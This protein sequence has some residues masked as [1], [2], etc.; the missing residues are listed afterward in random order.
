[1]TARDLFGKFELGVS[2]RASRSNS[3]RESDAPFRILVIGDFSGRKNRGLCE[4]IASRRCIKIDP[5]NFDAVLA[6]LEPQLDLELGGIRV[7]LTFAALDDFHPDRI[8]A[9]VPMVRDATPASFPSAPAAA[10]ATP[11]RSRKETDQ[12]TLQRLL[13]GASPATGTPAPSQPDHIRNLIA[14]A[15][16]PHI[17]ASPDPGAARTAEAI[18]LARSTQMRTILHHTHFQALEAAWRGVDSLVR[19]LETDNGVEICLLD[20]SAD[21]LSADLQSTDDLSTSGF[22]KKVVEETIQSPGAVAWSLIV[23]D[24]FFSTNEPNARC[25]ARAGKIAEACGAPLLTSLQSGLVDAALSRDGLKDPVWT[26]LRSFP[27]SSSIGVAAPR[28]LLRVPYGKS[29]DPID[30]FAFE[31]L[32]SPE[33][34]E[35]FL[36]GNPAFAIAR[37]IAEGFLQ[38]GWDFTPGDLDELT[39]LPHHSWR[40]DGEARMTPCAGRWLTDVEGERLLDAGIM[41]ILS[42]RGRNAVKLPRIQSIADPPAPLRGR[43][44]Q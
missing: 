16:A 14:Q 13:G 26:V 28:L 3:P 29:T 17:V 9:R 4:E 25:L 42:I 34:H 11:E 37:L 43:W 22:F 33:M 2:A 5:D 44:S 20:A 40:A 7:R 8:F 27:H 31:E 19:N 21:E 35:A 36:W 15:V 24:F 12:E 18:D 41:P 23:A 10:S 1:V 6:R 38:N 39:D 32:E 30:S